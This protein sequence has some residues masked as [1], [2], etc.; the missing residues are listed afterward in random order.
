MAKASSHG[1]KRAGAGRKKKVHQKVTVKKRS[2]Y[3]VRTL[4]GV[5]KAEYHTK[6]WS[7]RNPVTFLAI[8]TIVFYFTRSIMQSWRQ[9]AVSWSEVSVNFGRS[10]SRGLYKKAMYGLAT[11]RNGMRKLRVTPQQ[12]G[13]MMD[14]CKQYV[15]QS[16]TLPEIMYCSRIHPVKPSTQDPFTRACVVWLQ[17]AMGTA[18]RP[19]S[20]GEWL[21]LIAFGKLRQESAVCL[22]T[23]SHSAYVG[24][25]SLESAEQLGAFIAKQDTVEWHQQLTQEVSKLPGPNSARASVCL[26]QLWQLLSQ[27]PL[28]ASCASC[29]TYLGLVHELKTLPG[30][31]DFVAK[32]IAETVLNAIHLS[33]L[34]PSALG[35]SE[36]VQDYCEN[37]GAVLGPGPMALGELFFGSDFHKSKF[38]DVRRCVNNLC[39]DAEISFKDVTITPGQLTGPEMQS[40]WC[41]LK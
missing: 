33:D 24:F 8:A 30:H 14:G 1:G 21:A 23:P 5:E 31:G 13:K 29:S 15:G 36:A 4:L 41:K 37:P 22:L 28:L 7:T 10:D 2:P 38:E 34:D 3:Q 35:L 18:R 40:L 20:S 39:R 9:S 25:C 17:E 12:A 27:A 32:N 26:A 6:T 19:L 11:A 16:C